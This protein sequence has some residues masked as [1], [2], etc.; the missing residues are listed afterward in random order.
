MTVSAGS[1]CYNVDTLPVAARGYSYTEAE[2][3]AALDGPVRALVNDIEGRRRIREL[4]AGVPQTHFQKDHLERILN[5]D[6]EPQDWEVGEALAEAYV[7]IHRA[8]TFHWPDKWDQRKSRSSLPGADLAGLQ[9]TD[10]PLHRFRFA[11]G[12]VKTSEERTYPPGAMHGRHGLKQQ[13]EDLRDQKPIRDAL[14]RYLAFRAAGALWEAQYRSAA[15]RYLAD[16][17]DVTIFGVLIRDVPPHENDL[18]ARSQK[19]ASDSL[20]MMRI[21]LLAVYLPAG[22]VAR[23]RSY[24]HASGGGGDARH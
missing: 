3:D 4:L 24:Y 6:P 13:L 19:L 1:E 15:S 10:H 12:E 16:H 7:A 20:A 2:L 21:D 17:T 8:C 14:F 22:S 18:K 9:E 23:F 11:F 5:A